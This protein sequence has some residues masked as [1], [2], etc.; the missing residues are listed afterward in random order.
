MK[1]KFYLAPDRPLRESRGG[2]QASVTHLPAHTLKGATRPQGAD[3]D[4]IKYRGQDIRELS[5]R[6]LIQ[7]IEVMMALLE[8][9]R[10]QARHERKVLSSF[11]R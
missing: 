10:K 8:E 2:Q 11:H 7:A 3:M 1:Y 6:E 9:Q 5:R 4:A